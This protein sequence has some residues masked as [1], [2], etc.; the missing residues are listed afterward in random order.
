MKQQTSK[1]TPGEPQ[2]EDAAMVATAL[3]DKL[4]HGH[5]VHNGKRCK[6]N[7]DFTKLHFA[8]NLSDMQRRLLADMRFRCRTLPGTQEIRTKIGH[9]GFWA[10]VVY[11]NAIFMTIS[12]GERHNYLALRFF[13][14]RKMDPFMAAATED[15]INQKPW[16]GPDAPSLQPK[17]DEIYSVEIPGYDL[18]RL[19]MAQDPLCAANAFFVQIRT[20]LATALGIR[21]CPHCPH[22]A[23]SKNP[24]QD[25]FG[26]SAELMGGL[27]GRAD[28]MFGAVECQKSNGSLHYH[29]FVFLQ[30]LH[31]YCTLLE[32]AEILEKGLATAADLKDFIANIL[33]TS[34][35]DL[36]AHKQDGLLIYIARNAYVIVLDAHSAED[37]CIVL[38]E[39]IKYSH[40]N[41]RSAAMNTTR[42]KLMTL[43]SM[44]ATACRVVLDAHSA[45]NACIV[46]TTNTKLSLISHNVL[47]F[48]VRP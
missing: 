18:R 7:G 21:M 37:T 19:M 27:A 3:L 28:A 24:C 13:R 38:A 6:I 11:G 1:A 46:P 45:E 43:M 31:Q 15:A 2:A 48:H 30:R 9:L 33:C 42:R 14:Y 29:F 5:Y 41:A 20:I 16:C 26:S 8:E 22:C 32:I 10:I 34:Y 36:Q 25:A 44:L 39:I 4:N 47:L 12:P 40:V 23:A 17:A 35:N